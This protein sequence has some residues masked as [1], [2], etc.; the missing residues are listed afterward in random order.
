MATD[1]FRAFAFEL[2]FT[3]S[4]KVD[5]DTNTNVTCELTSADNFNWYLKNSL[6]TTATASSSVKTPI[7]YKQH[8]N[9]ANIISWPEGKGYWKIFVELISSCD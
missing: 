7:L 5:I 8:K 9:A 3:Q 4:Q 1:W 6:R 2:P